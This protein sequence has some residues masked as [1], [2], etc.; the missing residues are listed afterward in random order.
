MNR[1]TKLS[2][3]RGKLDEIPDKD[4]GRRLRGVI[5]TASNLEMT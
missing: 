1:T 4:R 5:L 2:D 3:L